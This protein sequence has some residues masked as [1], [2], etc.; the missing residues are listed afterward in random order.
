MA[1]AH[2]MNIRYGTSSSLLEGCK[3]SA[4]HPTITSVD[5]HSVQTIVHAYLDTLQTMM[6]DTAV[7]NK[8][9]AGAKKAWITIGSSGPSINASSGSPLK[10]APASRAGALYNFFLVEHDLSFGVHN[11]VYTIDLLKSS[12]AELRK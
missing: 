12:V 2:T 5:Y 1:G 10:I 3:N 4:C 8:F 6:A 7:V 11:S 9:N